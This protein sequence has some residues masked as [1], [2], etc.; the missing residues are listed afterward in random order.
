[1]Q[2]TNLNPRNF[3]PGTVIVTTF[4][5]FTVDKLHTSSIHAVTDYDGKIETTTIPYSMFS[6]RLFLDKL[7]SVTEPK[8]VYS[9]E[10][11]EFKGLTDLSNIEEY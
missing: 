5:T 1:M 8:E 7:I 2:T 6:N 4:N 10:Y 3:K 9:P 11:V